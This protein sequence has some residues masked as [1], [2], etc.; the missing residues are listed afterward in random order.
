MTRTLPIV[1]AVV[2]LTAWPSAQNMV[3]HAGADAVVLDVTVQRGKAPVPGLRAEDFEVVDSGVTQTVTDVSYS[4]VPIDL[5][6]VFDTSG[7]IT[8]DQLQRYL[9]AMIQITGALK[10]DDR[11]DILTFSTRVIEL[12]ALQAPPIAIN[13][14]RAMPRATSFYDAVGLSLV[15]ARVDGR[16]QLTIVLSDA[17]DNT[18]FFD[19]ET[20]LEMARR[21]DAVVYTVTPADAWQSDPD[22][23][24]VFRE[25]LERLAHLTGGR[26]IPAETDVV[27]AFLSAIEEFRQ[28]YVIMY[29]AAGVPKGGYHQIAVSVKGQKSLA[30]RT[31]QGYTG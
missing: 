20:M 13:L 31:R 3:F 6:L 10:S 9:R 19:N 26:M 1:A 7:S 8:D 21:T 28:S 24:K 23:G 12:A 5:R 30:V 29:N 27:P 11:C 25:R 16:R 18:S 4:R 22:R 2:A 17:D 14:R 15:T